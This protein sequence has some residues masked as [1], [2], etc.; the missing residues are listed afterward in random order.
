[1]KYLTSNQLNE[2]QL[3]QV[4]TLWNNEYPS[5]INHN[6][7]EHLQQYISGLA[8]PN[9]TLIEDGEGKIIGWFFDFMLNEERW[10]GMIVSPT[11]QGKGY[12]KEL[13]KRAKNNYSELNAWIVCS[14]EY[15]K[16][17]GETYNPPTEF[18][19]KMEFE[20]FPDLKFESN[21]LKTIKIKWKKNITTTTA[22]RKLR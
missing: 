11:H 18:Y 5:D 4:F 7:K 6:S 22:P 12:G 8:K 2:S 20:I 19:R 16:E 17:N 21:L 14:T 13:I 9:H 15:L 3:A 10:F 1:M